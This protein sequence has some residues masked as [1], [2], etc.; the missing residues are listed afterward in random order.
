MLK[1]N[2]EDSDYK[3]R[4]FCV[5]CASKQSDANL[6]INEIAYRLYDFIKSGNR[7]ER[8]VYKVKHD[9]T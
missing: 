3:L 5:E 6:S 2:R 9:T 1:F 4:K 8:H 7:I